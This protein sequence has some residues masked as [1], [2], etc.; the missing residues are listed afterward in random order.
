MQ[1]TYCPSCNSRLWSVKKYSAPKKLFTI[2]CDD[3]KYIEI[4]QWVY[5]NP[6]K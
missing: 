5:F 2:S 1:L 3:C 4:K 6:D